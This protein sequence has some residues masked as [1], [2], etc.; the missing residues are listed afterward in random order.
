MILNPQRNP[1]NRGQRVDR[2]KWSYDKSSN[3]LRVGDCSL[4]TS[5]RKTIFKAAVQDTTVTLEIDEPARAAVPPGHTIRKEDGHYRVAILMPWAKAQA[6]IEMAGYSNRRLDGFAYMDHAR[7][8][9]LLPDIAQSW[10]RFR[11]FYGPVPT[12]VE[13]RYGPKGEGPVGWIWTAPSLHPRPIKGQVVRN[14]DGDRLGLK[15]PSPKG[16]LI[17]TTEQNLF[18]YRP[19]RQY[20]LIGRLAKPWVGDPKVVTYRAKLVRPDGS[21]IRGILERTQVED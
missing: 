18:T 20:G 21:V 12:L 17:I 2:S 5:A 6:R 16:D 8:T 1:Y 9:L 4:T 10:Y 19:A 14:I 13:V 11:G 15:V 3:T 7:S